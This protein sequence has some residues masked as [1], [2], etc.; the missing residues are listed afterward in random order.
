MNNAD[1][2]SSLNMNKKIQARRR[3]ANPM[4]NSVWTR[5]AGLV[6]TGPPIVQSAMAMPYCI[7]KTSDNVQ[8]N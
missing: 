2:A 8:E 3:V 7:D 6:A 4:V 1:K 5:K